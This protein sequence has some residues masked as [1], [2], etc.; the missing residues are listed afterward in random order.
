MT[1]SL[2]HFQN[3]DLIYDTAYA[4]R[5][6]DL[7]IRRGEHCAIIGANGS[8]KS[9]LI[10]LISCELYPSYKNDPFCRDILE[11]SRWEIAELRKRLGVITNDIHWAFQMQGQNLRGYEAVL[12]GFNGTLGIFAHQTYTNEQHAIAHDALERLGIAHLGDK[13]LGNMSTGE[14]R[15]IVVARALVHPIDALLLDEPTVGLDIKAQIDF[16]DMIR[17]LS[18]SG[19]TIILVTHH[20]EEIFEEINKVVLLSGGTIYA[21]GKKEETLNSQNISA[22]FDMKLALEREGEHYRIRSF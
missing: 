18:R 20:I 5:G 1:D 2:I 15:K 10:K 8:G 21:Q 12:S 6:I 19:T 16:I 11:K 7:S 13:V 14:L 22:I 4:L 17:S 9:T 3:V